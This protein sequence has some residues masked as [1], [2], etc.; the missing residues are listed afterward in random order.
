MNK[1]G[2]MNKFES[3]I[4][5]S[6]HRE[7]ERISERMG[8]KEWMNKFEPGIKKVINGWKDCINEWKDE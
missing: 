8:I 5:K 4:K 6:N 7:D 3:D 1:W 2:W